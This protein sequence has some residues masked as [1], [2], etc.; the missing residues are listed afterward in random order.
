MKKIFF[1]FSFLL[2]IHSLSA[3]HAY[4][5]EGAVIDNVTYSLSGDFSYTCD[6]D[7]CAV[8][9][10]PYNLP[11]VSVSMQGNQI[12]ALSIDYD[13][14]IRYCKKPGTTYYDLPVIVKE[15]DQQY[16][17]YIRIHY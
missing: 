13:L 15:K 16:N 2:M 1:I 17:C 9:G 8:V 3:T 6:F 10:F 12:R 7:N 4:V 5:Y 11:F 14:F